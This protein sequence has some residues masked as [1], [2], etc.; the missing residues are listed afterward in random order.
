[1]IS[2]PSTGRN[3]SARPRR[4]PAKATVRADADWVVAPPSAPFRAD[5][6]AAT[7]LASTAAR[8]TG[9]SELVPTP[10]AQSTSTNV[11]AAVAAIRR[12]IMGIDPLGS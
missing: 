8:L 5:R 10:L 11:P 2:G 6:S 12:F 4:T 7:D 1:M 3:G 9:G